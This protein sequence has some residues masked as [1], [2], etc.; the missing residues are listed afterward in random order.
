MFVL[1]P[2]ARAESLCG[3]L[4]DRAALLLSAA[5]TPHCCRIGVPQRRPRAPLLEQVDALGWSCISAS[6]EV[7]EQRERL[8]TR[9]AASFRMRRGTKRSEGRRGRGGGGR[10]TAITDMC[11]TRSD[12]PAEVCVWMDRRRRRSRRCCCS[13]GGCLRVLRGADRVTGSG[14]VARFSVC[15]SSL[16]VGYAALYSMPSVSSIGVRAVG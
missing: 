2:S 11:A 7:G 13:R 10:A 9:R 8:A 12:A 14:M 1:R 6:M 3:S 15:S 16:V 4:D 5:A